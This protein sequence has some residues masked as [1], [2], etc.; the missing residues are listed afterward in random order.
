MFFIYNLTYLKR[1]FNR[2]KR[3]THI[4]ANVVTNQICYFSIKGSLRGELQGKP[5]HKNLLIYDTTLYHV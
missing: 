5:A 3:F 4:Q 2:N 1:T